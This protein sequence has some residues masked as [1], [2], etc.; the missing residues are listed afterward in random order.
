MLRIFGPGTAPQEPLASST[1][2][3][4]ENISAGGGRRRIYQSNRIEFLKVLEKINDA[5][6][7]LKTL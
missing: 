4:E 7:M 3:A 2:E 6:N 1:T 5:D